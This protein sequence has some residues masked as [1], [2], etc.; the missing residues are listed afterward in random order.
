MLQMPSITMIVTRFY[1]QEASNTATL[2]SGPVEQAVEEALSDVILVI[3]EEPRN[4]VEL[5][6]I[7]IITTFSTLN[8]DD[9]EGIDELGRQKNSNRH[10]RNKCWN[11]IFRAIYL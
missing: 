7:Y 8:D 2:M 4:S 10:R 11:P 9:S 5:Y 3:K 1:S 6:H